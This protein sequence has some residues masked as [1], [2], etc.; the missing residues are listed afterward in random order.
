MSVRNTLAVVLGSVAFSALALTG[1]SAGAQE[2]PPAPAAAPAAPAPVNFAAPK[3]GEIDIRG[4]K[5]GNQERVVFDFSALPELS[6]VKLMKHEVNKQK[7]V[8]GGSGEPVDGM[9]GSQFLHVLLQTNGS[10]WV[11]AGPETFD[12]PTAESGV[13]NDNEGGTVELT[14]GLDAGVKYDVEVQG[15]KVVINMTRA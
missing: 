15:E 7:P 11:T 5:H 4:G 12:L 6:E 14:V 2:Q 13:V 1:C 9:K 10:P 8:W 3:K